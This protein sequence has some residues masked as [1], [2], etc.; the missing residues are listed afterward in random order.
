[1]TNAEKYEEV[2]GMKVDKDMCP[3]KV[4]AICPIKNKKLRCRCKNT[5][6]WWES[7]YKE[8]GKE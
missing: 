8:R 6:K 1:M 2:F 5:E 3:T 4:C 7:E